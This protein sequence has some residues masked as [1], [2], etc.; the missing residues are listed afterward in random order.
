MNFAPR[1]ENDF[2]Q[3]IDTYYQCC[4]SMFDSIE[5]IAGKWMYRDLIPGMSDFDTRF[6][7]RDSMTTE[8][9]CRM[10]TAVGDVH[11][12]LCRKHPCWARNLEHLPGINVTWSELTAES[13]YYPEYNQWSFY[14]SVVPHKVGSTREHLAR[15]SW[16][17]KDEYLYLKRFCGYYGRY[18]RS[19]DPPI[20]LGVH[21]NKYPLH[22]R[23][24][25]Y[26]TPAVQS[27]VC[28]L[29]KQGI[30]GKFDSLEIAQRR[31]PA[32]EKCWNTVSEILHANYETPQWY[33]EPQISQL[34]DQLENALQAI[35]LE[36]RPCLTLIP[37]ELG[38]DVRAWSEALKHAEIDASLVI[39][40]SARF[41]R[42][43][44]GRLQFYAQAPAHFDA[45]WLIQHEVSRIGRN[46]FQT[47]FSLYWKI[48]TGEALSDATPILDKLRGAG[49][50]T[51]TEA[52][53]TWE[54][55]RLTADGCKDHHPR[56][57]AAAVAD[58]FDD[59]FKALNKVR[60]AVTEIE[61]QSAHGA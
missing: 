19:I 30:A 3:F 59:F 60:D 14:H 47:P 39:L 58:V 29:E 8:D 35:S 17:I 46:F 38:H 49:L 6:I 48:R 57:R 51:Q 50:L 20:N 22:S 23:L 13:S 54:L 37:K 34:E 45:A 18:N 12:M 26:F 25:H 42:L 41:S 33:R 24:M 11:L 31:F 40:E 32:L 5:A 27:A 7:V 15:R 36:L 16:G 21:Q 56:Y 1:P 52:E 43:M 28:L 44:K 2:V 4:R 61:T 10:S 9:W 53:A 55:A